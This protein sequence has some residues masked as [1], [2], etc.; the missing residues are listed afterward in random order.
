[1]PDWSKTRP[2]A[3][4]ATQNPIPGQAVKIADTL[5]DPAVGDGWYHL[6]ASQSGPDRRLGRQYVNG[7]FSARQPGGCW[8]VSR[9]HP[10]SL[11]L[12][13]LSAPRGASGRA[14]RT[15]AGR[16]AQGVGSDRSGSVS[17][18]RCAANCGQQFCGSLM[19][20][21]A[22]RCSGSIAPEVLPWDGD[23]ERASARYRVS[24]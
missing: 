9:D 22:G 4:M 19:H 14:R 21:S 10:R 1:M 23:L 13:S 15:Y 2:L 11:P 6:V 24:A 3:C 18:A 8:R 7:S 17:G 5:P 16:F 20:R 12:R